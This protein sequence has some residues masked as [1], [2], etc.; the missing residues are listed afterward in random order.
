MAELG[1]IGMNKCDVHHLVWRL[2][3]YLRVDVFPLNC[4]AST[5]NM[6]SFA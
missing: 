4:C 5:Y 6:V 2:E 1:G 3:L